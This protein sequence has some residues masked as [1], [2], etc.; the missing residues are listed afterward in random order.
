M[1]I[2]GTPVYG[3]R[4]GVVEERGGALD[5]LTRKTWLVIQRY[6][7]V[8][9]DVRT[10]NTSDFMF[11]TKLG[12]IKQGSRSATRETERMCVCIYRPDRW[13][14]VYKIKVLFSNEEWE[15]TEPTAL[16][17]GNIID[18]NCLREEIKKA[19]LRQNPQWLDVVFSNFNNE[20]IR[21]LTPTNTIVEGEPF[22]MQ[23]THLN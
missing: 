13:R 12:I 3:G 1:S 18:E 8:P 10:I 2:F 14:N 6:L 17:I 19:L 11:Q 16:A 5:V 7:N 15:I 9:Y 4:Q 22:V 23:Q 21:E 20:E